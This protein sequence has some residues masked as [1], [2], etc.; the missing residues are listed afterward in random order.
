MPPC[1]I[2]RN[3]LGLN[4]SPVPNL[5]RQ[6]SINRSFTFRRRPLPLWRALCMKRSL[7]NAIFKNALHEIMVTERGLRPMIAIVEPEALQFVSLIVSQFYRESF[8]FSLWACAHRLPSFLVP[9]F[10]LEL[11]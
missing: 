3:Y 6:D 4:I 11:V 2:S 1:F 5:S 7:V 10:L 8:P 9:F